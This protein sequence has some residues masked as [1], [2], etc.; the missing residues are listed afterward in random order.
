MAGVCTTDVLAAFGAELAGFTNPNATIAI[1]AN[2]S[3]FTTN[4]LGRAA[5]I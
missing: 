1:R 5:P 3:L 2:A 4:L